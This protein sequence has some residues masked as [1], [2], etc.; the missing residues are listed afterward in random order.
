MQHVRRAGIAV[1]LSVVLAM[2]CLAQA[3]HAQARPSC[4]QGR[5]SPTSASPPAQSQG[6]GAGVFSATLPDGSLMIW[7]NRP[8]D[9]FFPGATLLGGNDPFCVVWFSDTDLQALRVEMPAGEPVP[10]AV[11]V[12]VCE[13]DNPSCRIPSLLVILPWG[14]VSR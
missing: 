12:G 13:R 8:G 14:R 5:I 6:S 4:A 3:A 9:R 10:G 1:L 7:M 2:V 11:E